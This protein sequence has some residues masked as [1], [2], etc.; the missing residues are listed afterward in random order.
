MNKENYKIRLK[1]IT[2]FIFDVDGVLTDGKLLITS[3]GE[4]LRLMDAKDGFAMKYAIDKGFKI[5]IISGGKD[6]SI[7]KRIE[8]LGINDIYLDSHNKID[9]YNHLLNK[10]KLSANNIL[11]MGDDIPDIPVMEK[12]GISSCPQD[13]VTDVKIKADYISHKNGGNGCVREIIE[14]VLRVQKKWKYTN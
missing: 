2:T 14:Q 4:I 12:V 8:K 6:E 3:N 1:N 7:R 10:Y 9:S 5:S 13:A 11:Y